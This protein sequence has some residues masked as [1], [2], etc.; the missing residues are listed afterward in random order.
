MAYKSILVQVDDSKHVDPRIE[1]AARLAAKEDAHLIGVAVT[2]VAQ[3]MYQSVAIAPDYPDINAFIEVLQQRAEAALN[4]FEATAQRLGVKSFEKRTV[5][6]EAAVGIGA[7]ARCCDL[8]I[9][10]QV[11]QDDRDST[12]PADFAEYV[13]MS[14]GGPALIVPYRNIG[15]PLGDKVMIAWNGSM[16]ATRAV[17]NAVPLLQRAKAVE[18]AIL[19]PAFST[20]DVIGTPPGADLKAY[21]ARHNINAGIIT[22]KS[23][24]EAGKALLTLA[25]NSG[26]DLIVM[27]CYGHSRFRE[28]LLGGAT[29]SMIKSTTIPLLMSH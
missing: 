7:Q 17:H 29:R 12:V 15:H 9:L 16:E 21:L 25:Q 5:D 2:G 18:I 3:F 1:I 27:G 24:E 26:A 10:G 22:H 14:C 19:N 11:D 8:A 20:D 6:D 28:I 13:V 23:D 4:R